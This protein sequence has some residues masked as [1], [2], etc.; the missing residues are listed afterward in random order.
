MYIPQSSSWSIAWKV[1]AQYYGT[2]GVGA[3]K[4]CSMSGLKAAGESNSNDWAGRLFHV[5]IVLA[6]KENSKEEVLN[7]VREIYTYDWP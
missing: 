7:L 1:G 6:A 4:W 3:Y 5:L 2:V